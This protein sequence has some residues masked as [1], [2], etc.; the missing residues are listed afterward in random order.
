[1]QASK[2]HGLL[3]NLLAAPLAPYRSSKSKFFEP[4]Q[5]QGDKGGDLR[6]ADIR[7]AGD[8]PHVF[9]HIKKTYRVQW[10]LLEGGEDTPPAL[11]PTKAAVAPVVTSPRG[12]DAIG[13]AKKNVKTSGKDLG[14][15]ARW[16]P[17]DDVADAK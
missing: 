12:K 10:V 11:S 6:I 17:L 2:A 9:S 7:A 4:K 1:M 13:K 8:V 15:S 16:L 3:T 14:G 5:K